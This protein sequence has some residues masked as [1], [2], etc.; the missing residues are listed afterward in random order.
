MISRVSVLL[1]VIVVAVLSL[2]AYCA[3]KARAAGDSGKLTLTYDDGK[4]VTCLTPRWSGGGAQVNV[5]GASGK[6]SVGGKFVPVAGWKAGAGY[7]IGL[8]TNG[9][10]IVNTEEYQ[11]VA[12]GGSVVLTAKIGEKE[13][14]I[15]CSEVRLS[16]DEKKGEVRNMRWRM[17]GVYGWVGQIASVD[18]RILDENLDGKYSTNGQDAIRIGK[19]RLALPLRKR[20]RIGEDFYELKISED[21]STLE[22]RKLNDLPVGLVRTPFAGKYLV[23][24][25]MDGAGG[26]FDIQACAKTGIPAGDYSVVYG[27]V[28]NPKSPVA[29]YSGRKAMLKYKIEADK[30][31]LM[32]I[33]PPLQLVFGAEYKQEEKNNDKNTKPAR[34]Q[35]IHRIGV[36]K[37]SKVIGAAGEEYGP[38][39]FPNVRSPRGRPGIMILQGSRTL[40]KTAMPQKDGNLH[41][42]WYEL[43]RKFSPMSI[44]VVM[45]ASVVGLG[46]VTGSRTLKQIYDKEAAAP[47]KTDQPSVSTTPWKRP[48]RSVRVSVK[49]KPPITAKPK[50]KPKPTTRP[51]IVKRPTKPPKSSSSDETKARR[52]LKLAESYEKMSLEDKYI[53]TLRKIVDKYPKT[54]AAF[55]AQTLLTTT[56]Q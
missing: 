15:R 27:A 45:V 30:K 4:K 26:A 35:M 43:P 54:K 46:K 6:A 33:G 12:E 32:R 3:G 17:Q 2:S 24:L 14:S 13:L 5:T 37:P 8:D 51:A 23:G 41:D 28:G 53:G 48:G 7:R 11:N 10:G 22:H 21:G 50:P 25:V 52:M 49:P 20:H 1:S 39:V 18:I 16:Y 36:K 56:G 38:L 19:A 9:D 34:K 55:T 42:F 31:N 44:R 29:L 40:V 47:P